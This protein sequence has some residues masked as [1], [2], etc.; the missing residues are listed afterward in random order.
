MVAT[1]DELIDA[2]ATG[3]VYDFVMVPKGV[4]TSDPEISEEIRAH[5]E[6]P[7]VAFGPALEGMA[8]AEVKAHMFEL[9]ERARKVLGLDLEGS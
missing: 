2:L 8:V 1:P 6:T 9:G 4:I 3:R 5:A 7:L